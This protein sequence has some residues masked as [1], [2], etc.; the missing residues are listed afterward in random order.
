VIRENENIDRI[1][2][3]ADRRTPSRG[4]RSILTSWLGRPAPR[5]AAKRARPEFVELESRDNPAYIFVDFGDNFPAGG[6]SDTLNNF[7]SLK[8]GANPAVNGPDLTFI[9]NGSATLTINSYNS[10]FGAASTANRAEIM[11][12][13]RRYYE[14]TGVTVVELKSTPTI[15]DGFSFTAAKTLADV[16]VTLGLNEGK[17][18]NNDSYSFVGQGILTG[19]DMLLDVGLAGIANG[20]DLGFKAN[21]IDDTNLNF[22][23]PSFPLGNVFDG[24]TIAHEN[25][26]NLGLRHVY[27]TSGGTIPGQN[28]LQLS[29]SEVMSYNRF[30][31]G[32]SDAMTMFS[33][34]PTILGDGN[35]NPDTLSVNAPNKG[36]YEQFL[37]DPEVGGNP[38]LNF[39]SGTGANDIITISKT[40]ANQATV[41][42]APFSNNTYT[43]ALVV[44]GQSKTGQTTYT[45]TISLDKQILIDAG[46]GADRLVL[47][48]DLGVTVRYRAMDGVDSL[49]VADAGGAAVTYSP[50]GTKGTTLDKGSDFRAGL[51]YGG[52]IVAIQEFEATSSVSVTN[53][54]VVTYVSPGG[55]DKITATGAAGGKVTVT[56]TVN[57]GTAAVPLTLTTINKL[58]L[59]LGNGEAAAANDTVTIL[60]YSAANPFPAGGL[61]YDGGLGTDS[62]TLAA[63]ADFALSNSALTVSGIGTVALT[64]VEAATLTGG[65]SGNTFTISGWTGSASVDG[66]TGIDTIVFAQDADITLAPTKLTTST[67][68]TINLGSIENANLTG[69]AADNTFDLSSWTGSST[70]N[71]LGGMDTIRLIRDANFTAT[72]SLIS[73]SDGTNYPVANVELLNLTG[74]AGNNSFDLNGWTGGGTLDGLAG[75]DDV[76]IT[77]DADFGLTASTLTVSVGL[78]VTIANLENAALTG[79]ISQNTFTL[80]G[81]N[82]NAVLDGQEG[83][84]TYRITPG[85]KSS[86]IAIADSG[87]GGVDAVEIIGTGGDDTYSIEPNA[88]TSGLQVVSYANVESVLVDGGAGDDTFISNINKGF[89]KGGA[90]NLEGGSGLNTYVITGTPVVPIAQSGVLFTSGS[91]G[92]ILLDPDGS[93]TPSLTGPRGGD[94][95][96]IAF[97]NMSKI[98][99]VTPADRFDFAYGVSNDTIAVTDGGVFAG[100]P[101]VQVFDG[102]RGVSVAR[103]TRVV[104]TGGGGSDSF[105]LNTTAAVPGVTA[106]DL[107]GGG[108]ADNFV[109]QAAN[110]PVGLFGLG[111]DDTFN[112]G[113]AVAGL[114]NVTANVTIDGDTGTNAVSLD[115]SA[116]TTANPAVAIAATGVTGLTGAGAVT[117]VTGTISTL[118]VIGSSAKANTV[119]VGTLGFPLVLTTGTAADTVTLAAIGAPATIATGGSGDTVQING[120]SAGLGLLVEDGD[121]AVTFGAAGGSLDAFTV[122]FAFDGGAGSDTATFHDGGDATA[123]AYTLAAAGFTRT[124]GVSLSYAN[125][126][127]A[128]LFGGSADN[129]YA[130]SGLTGGVAVTDGDGNGT[131]TIAGNTLG[132]TNNFAGAGGNDSFAFAGDGIAAATTIDAGTGSDSAAVRGTAGADA[133]TVTTNALAGTVAGAGTGTLT[134]AGLETL[135]VDSLA[136]T[137]ALTYVDGTASTLAFQFVPTTGTGGKLT[138]P[139]GTTALNFTNT[140]GA[141]SFNGGSTRDSLTVFGVSTTGKGSG[142]ETTAANGVD[143]VTV[144]DTSVAITNATLGAMRTIAVASSAG[145]PTV[146]SLTVRTGNESSDSAD[147][148]T[149]TPSATTGIL[150]YGGSP[151]KTPG[152]KLV[153]LTSGPRTVSLDSD[154]NGKPITRVTQLSNGATVGF[155]EFETAPRVEIVAAGSGPGKP[156]RV[157]VYDAGSGNQKLDFSPFGAFAGGVS[158]ATGDVNGDQYPDVIVSAGPGMAPKV[159]VYD[160]I[161][162]T[163]LA[164]FLAYDASFMG[165]VQVAAGDIDGDALADIVIGCGIGGG[166][167]VQA[168][169]GADFSTRIQN[170]FAYDMNFRSG[171]QVAVGD[172]NGDG[173]ADIITGAGPG[174]GPHVRA[175]SGKDGAVLANYFA[176]DPNYRGGVNVT[177]GDVFGD[178]NVVILAAP[179]AAGGTT[180]YAYDGQTGALR[181]TF[182]AAAGPT[183][184]ILPIAR[185]DG[186]RMTTADIDG[187]GIEDVITARGRGTQPVLRAFKLGSTTGA[188][189]TVDLIRETALFDTSFTGGV[190]VG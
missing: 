18:A 22:V 45:Y 82:G 152:D 93:I 39:V 178:G 175:F 187:D 165:G 14:S 107:I 113:T 11:Q 63:D 12:I 53:A 30:N 20:T 72:D 114:D 128:H 158:V 2:T 101:T 130:V 84:D 135:G 129:S 59:N 168:I 112:L 61:A 125:V 146:K 108:N 120:I 180:V 5:P 67:G 155:A 116:S 181:A 103:K 13:V 95:T 57:G 106:F 144:S 50:A 147:Q 126:E 90:F 70:I 172:V 179:A 102:A 74:G 184:G 23:T 100:T 171:V 139:A 150:I 26:H 190:Y 42:V 69:G 24:D 109:L 173:R 149:V 174:G 83:S 118:N 48:N 154:A 104:I 43:S 119:S 16:S 65:A 41:T 137:N 73:V 127:Q 21:T 98:G 25:G 153:V 10:I 36:T 132:G 80:V 78:P 7:K 160:G 111:G 49:V 188:T 35:G 161:F 17:S 123:N 96:V 4:F 44:P 136:G 6:L 156:S 170:F 79:G 142:T 51:T 189:G 88:V 131:F 94:E 159:K 105:T 47:A 162:G 15:V 141:F 117:F 169:S 133:V 110:L 54:G 85:T 121:D 176:F 55:V 68:T 9:A 185:E 89:F 145:V 38:T 92:E 32:S 97:N 143:V 58:A 163:E 151:S 186:I 122:P 140:N 81:W 34:F 27:Q 66:A 76:A 166:P 1:C 64:A 19:L 52:T 33:R 138:G 37:N 134:Y 167:H 29:Q 182:N 46:P 31:N 71:G 183:G 28:W 75:T 99:D 3:M 177:A 164:S 91:K 62:I 157:Q 124:G 60:G 115:D 8:S 40:G 87:T 148:V 86:T 56:G 77:R